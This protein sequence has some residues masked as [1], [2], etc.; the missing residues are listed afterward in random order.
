MCS[1]RIFLRKIKGEEAMNKRRIYGMVLAAG[2]GTRLRPLTDKIPKP[3]LDVAGQPLLFYALQNMQEAGVSR[4]V[5]NTHHLA[6]QVV[7]AA[8]RK[9]WPFEVCFNHEPE[10]LGTGGAI[11][12]AQEKLAGADAIVMHNSDA[13][14]ECD[15]KALISTHFAE[16]PLATMVLKTVPDPDSY[17]A[18]V[19]DA[20]NH[21]RDI[22]GAINYKGEV[23]QR[24]MYCGV[25]V[26]NPTIFEYMPS[27]GAFCIL[28]QV[29]IPAIKG[30]SHV[31]GVPNPGFFCDVGTQERLEFARTTFAAGA[32][33]RTFPCNA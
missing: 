16:N 28:R 25:Q 1:F 27:G 2:L 5:I 4:V 11:R 19:T 13:I 23:A 30:G 21:V 33:E 7:A 20:H 26:L 10:I 8:S 15:M 24:R 31:H 12:N 17:G 22:V 29:L 32:R 18:V 3:A 9:Q 6:E 14:I